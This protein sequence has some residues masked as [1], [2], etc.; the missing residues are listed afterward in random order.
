MNEDHTEVAQT[1]EL[2][3]R[4]LKQLLCQHSQQL[5]TKTLK[6]TRTLPLPHRASFPIHNT[7]CHDSDINHKEG[8]SPQGGSQRYL[9]PTQMFAN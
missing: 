4:I 2:E 9:E 6:K 3:I 8:L 7:T 1:L 5:M